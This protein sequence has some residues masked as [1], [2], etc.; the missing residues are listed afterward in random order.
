MKKVLFVQEGGYDFHH[1]LFMLHLLRAARLVV[2]SDDPQI[3]VQLGRTISALFGTGCVLLFYLLI[4]PFLTPLFAVLASLAL[5][6]SPMVVIHSHYLKEDIYLVQFNTKG[7]RLLSVGYAGTIIIRDVASG[8]AIF[9]T[10]LPVVTY[11]ACY[12]PDGKRIA[13]AANDGKTYLIDVPANA[14]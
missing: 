10:K 6:T 12:S 3:I 13:V 5:A 1:P 9:T 8:N 2:P 7:N 11:S 4:R 14:Q